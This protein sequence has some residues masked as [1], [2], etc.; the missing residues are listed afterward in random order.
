MSAPQPEPVP[1]PP[2]PESDDAPPPPA[3]GAPAGAAGQPPAPK[4]LSRST[5]ELAKVLLLAV[6]NSE[7]IPAWAAGSR[8]NHGTGAA[9]DEVIA[10]VKEEGYE[11]PEKNTVRKYLT[12]EKPTKTTFTSY[13]DYTYSKGFLTVIENGENHKET[14]G[15]ED[16]VNLPDHSLNQVQL[17]IKAW[18]FLCQ[19]QPDTMETDSDLTDICES[20]AEK[21]RQAR[22]DAEQRRLEGTAE[23]EVLRRRGQEVRD[24]ASAAVTVKKEQVEWE[25]ID[26]TM[27]HD[28]LNLIVQSGERSA[29]EMHAIR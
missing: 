5:P 9:L 14:G 29:E 7:Y 21:I 15:L 27:R 12:G 22:L 19:G 25:I 2:A 1:E 16:V 8:N 20:I 11:L 3:S 4:K 23:G 13:K 26:Y 28:L 18:F 17:A 6:A 10:H 24:L